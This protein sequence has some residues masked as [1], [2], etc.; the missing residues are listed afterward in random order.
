LHS[1][2]PSTLGNLRTLHSSSG[3]GRNEEQ[4]IVAL[5]GAEPWK[6]EKLTPVPEGRRKPHWVSSPVHGSGRGFLAP[7]GPAALHPYGLWLRR[8]FRAS[9]FLD[10]NRLAR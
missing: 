3:A 4:W 6:T 2:A 5:G 10:R 9:G 8:S 1:E 7:Q